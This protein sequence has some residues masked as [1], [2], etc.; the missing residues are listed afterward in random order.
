MNVLE[1]RRQLVATGYTVIP[2]YGKAPPNKGTTSASTEASTTGS[3]S[4]TSPTRC[5]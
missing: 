5:W 3:S 4:T 2:L 1:R